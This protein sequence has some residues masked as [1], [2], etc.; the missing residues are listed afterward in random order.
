MD[1]LLLLRLVVTLAIIVLFCDMYLTV[2]SFRNIARPVTLSLSIM[3]LLAY[4]VL[5]QI[6][7]T[8]IAFMLNEGY[9]SIRLPELFMNARATIYGAVLLLIIPATVILRRE[10]I[11]WN[12]RHILPSSVKQGLDILPDG[13]LYYDTGGVVRFINP[14]M[15]DIADRLTGN[16]VLNGA[17]LY[18]FVRNGEL[19]GGSKRISEGDA[20]VIELENGRI[21][22]FEQNEKSLKG[23]KLYE[24]I[25][26]DVTDEYTLSEKLR[27]N[28][29]RLEEQKE[30]LLTLGRSITEMIIE[31]EMLDAKARIHDDLGKGL[32]AS[33]YYIEQGKGTPD[34]IAQLWRTNIRIIAAAI[35]ESVTNTFRHAKGSAVYIDVDCDVTEYTV[36]THVSNLLQKTGFTNRTELAIKARVSGL[37]VSRD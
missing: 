5:V 1:D 29:N 36:K 27:E 31:R 14:A 18:D 35:R 33:R 20:P 24:L 11:D 3:T 16:Q 22:S 32:T 2:Y 9:G 23:R 12:S 15:S 7:S 8:K 13:L 30:R 19:T 10:L 6:G 26:F 37:V 25:C 4:F 28:R 21:Y 34:E 17:D